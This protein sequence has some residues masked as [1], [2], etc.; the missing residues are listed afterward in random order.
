MTHEDDDYQIVQKWEAVTEV[1]VQTPLDVY[2]ELE[3]QFPLCTLP[4]M[5]S[6]L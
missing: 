3:G 1:D 2:R 6:Q 4:K 5:R